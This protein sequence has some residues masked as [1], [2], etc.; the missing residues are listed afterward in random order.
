MA[1][2][3]ET[4]CLM[5]LHWLAVFAN[6]Q[7]LG[8]HRTKSKDHSQRLAQLMPEEKQAFLLEGVSNT[9]SNH[10]HTHC[11]SILMLHC[12]RVPRTDTASTV[13]LL[14]LMCA[15][16]KVAAYRNAFL[17][18][19]KQLAAYEAITTKPQSVHPVRL[20]YSQRRALETRLPS[21]PVPYR[22]TVP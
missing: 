10:A 19:K 16:Q 22:K 7:A 12:S 13:P 17:K 21:N 5:W 9:T 1:R 18:N 11:S 3:N 2:A 8:V 15:E 6:A 20:N 4:K 14:L